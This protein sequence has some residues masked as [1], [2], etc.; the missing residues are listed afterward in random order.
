MG[1]RV[2][3]LAGLA[4]LIAAPAFAGE[5]KEALVRIGGSASSVEKNAA[6]L[7]VQR[8]NEAGLNEITIE[9]EG[10]RKASDAGALVI[11]LG[12]PE[13]HAEIASI[14]AARRI[15]PFTPVAPGPEGFLLQSITDQGRL[16]VLAAGVD[17]R[18][19][20]Y[21]V[22][23]ILRQALVKEKA[24]EFPDKLDVRTAPAFEVRGTQIGQ[25]GVMLEKAKAR[26]WT[27]A[28]RQ[29]AIADV[30]LA[31]GN[32]IALESDSTSGK[33][34]AY[35]Y[36]KS[37]GMK[38]LY[39]Y[40]PNVGQGPPEWQAKESIGRGN[41]LC[42]SVTEARE[43]LLK[44]CEATFKD[45][46]PMEYVR[47]VGGDGGGCECDRCKPFGGVFIRL[48]EDC[49]A[50]IHKYHPKAE[51]FITNQK[52]EDASDKAIF[53]YLQEKP[54]P[55]LRAFC[56]GPGSDGMSWQPGHRQT[57]AMELFKYPGFG[58]PSRY[59]HEILHQLPPEQD[60]VF[61]NEITHWRYSEF[62]FAQA[63]PRP[64]KE[65]IHP[66]HWNDFIY[67]RMPERYLTMVYDRLSF[68]AWP[69]FYHW[70]FG[71]TVRYGIGDV[72]HSSGTHDHFNQ[73][74]WERLMWDPQ[75]SVED[76][77]DEYARTWFGPEAAPM[78]AK[79]LFQLEQ[80]IQDDP[81]TPLPQKEG[82]S[83]YYALVKEAGEKMPDY[84][85][86]TNWLWREYMQK[87]SVDKHTALAVA[88]QMAIEKRIEKRIAKALNNGNL[89]AA[90]RKALS[91]IDAPQETPEMQALRDEAAR[92]GEESNALY[93][94]R[95]EGIYNLDHDFIG[96]GWTKRQ[97]ERAKAAPADEKREL[98][99]MIADYE[100]P[101]EGGF[102]DNCG[103]VSAMPHLV[104]GYPYD[105]GQPYVPMM[106]SEGNRFS[107]KTMCATQEQAQGVSFRY[108]GLD[109]KARYRVRMTLVRPKFQER[110]EMRMNQRAESVYADD[111]PLAKGVEIPERM[112]DIFTFD[113]PQEA[114]KDGELTIR[115]EKMPD[116]ANGDRVTVEQWRNT[117][118]WGTIISEIWLMKVK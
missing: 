20:V 14:F 51:I 29:H 45:A 69:R 95:S 19:V 105:F 85:R 110:Y 70:A 90:I 36:V 25:S 50:I 93:G 75:R 87:A 81:K 58:P 99:A 2:T 57:H 23:E 31:G 72:T 79:A 68:F 98:L 96:L 40:T 46:A 16:T 15:P 12:I 22:G 74:M 91:W 101:G 66:P 47:L 67:K 73:W 8:L 88:G 18:G 21:A 35:A 6:E 44:K 26:K 118:G 76:I 65:G 27:E 30:F 112:S 37:L 86:K 9:T 13:H 102:Y 55:W 78:M 89:D 100:N 54:R 1:T 52:F 5:F 59:L 104:S 41:Y 103:S 60:I 63:Y 113:V 94:V 56:Y 84:R 80:N 82:I 61:Y 117:G 109:P 116:V 48:C 108:D 34:T 53:K 33:D 43:A 17:D 7:L 97:L 106:L 10:K 114:T 3:I 32:T 38:T 39:H 107:Q 64:D 111:I 11:L 24:I 4:A 42:P 71:E 49:A 62:G 115:L 83:T 92:I 28:E 77:V